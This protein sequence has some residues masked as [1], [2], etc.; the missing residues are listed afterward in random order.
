MKYLVIPIA[1]CIFGTTGLKAQ[2]KTDRPVGD[3]TGVRA[4]QGLHVTLSQEESNTVQIESATADEANDIQTEVKDGILVIKQG[5]KSGSAKLDIHLKTLNRVE[6]S[7]TADVRSGNTFKSDEIHVHCG[8]AARVSLSS[9]TKKIQAE[10]SGAGVVSLDGKT[11]MLTATVSGAGKL[12]ALELSAEN[13]DIAGS[14]AGVS[15]V[16]VKQNLKATVS[17]AGDVIYREEPVSKS[18]ELSGAGSVRNAHGKIGSEKSDTTRFT[19]GHN[20]I[21]ISHDGL[22]PED[23]T[24]TKEDKKGGDFKHWTGLEW[25]VNGLRTPLKDGMTLPKGQEYMQLDLN[26]SQSF[27]LNLFEHDFKLYKNYVKLFTGLGF[28]FNHYAL[29]NNVS[30]RTDSVY[31]TARPE[32]KLSF[33]KNNLNENLLTVPLMLEFNT[34]DNSKKSFHVAV[35]LLGGWKIGSKSR[36]NFKDEDGKK[37][38]RMSSNDYN[39]DPFRYSLSARIGYRNWSVFGNYALSEFFKSGHGPQLYPASAG[40]AWHW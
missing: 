2:L 28:E 32:P 18:I 25:G 35:G 13:A 40:I 3:F 20:H 31:T 9:E 27:S 8:S 30:L 11:E 19:V 33:S 21:T 7:G 23:S 4:G 15:K 34:S 12:D 6:V 1:F 5:K 17:G 26:K 16:N 14:G 38:S 36:Q 22:D 39:M 29:Q 37:I 24:G 10:V